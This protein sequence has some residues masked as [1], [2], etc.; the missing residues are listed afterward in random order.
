MRLPIII[1][2]FLVVLSLSYRYFYKND[3]P[4]AKSVFSWSF[5]LIL[6]TILGNTQLSTIADLFT[7]IIILIIVLNDGYDIARSI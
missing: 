4:T 2:T 5:I 1:A 6:L 3:K 7:Y